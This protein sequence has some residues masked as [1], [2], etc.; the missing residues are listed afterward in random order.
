MLL[1]NLAQGGEL[2]APG[3]R[4]HNIERALL[5][6]DLREEPIKIAKVRHV[7]L[8]AGDIF[9]E[10]PYRRSQL[11][12]TPAGDE[13]IRAFVHKLLRRCQADAARA[14][15]DQGNFSFKPLHAFLLSYIV[16]NK[17][18][19]RCLPVGPSV[20]AVSGNTIAN[21]YDDRHD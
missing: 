10:L 17:G 5:L 3:I 15:G 1:S 7:S 13:P 9:S 11:R 16:S 18:H 14:T 21:L 8:D 4:E 12:F 19:F 2:R 20:C 6:F